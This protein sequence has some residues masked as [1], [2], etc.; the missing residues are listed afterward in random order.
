VTNAV[1]NPYGGCGVLFR[2]TPAG[3]Y[4]VLYNF[5][6]Q[7]NCTDGGMA[8]G[9]MQATNGTFYGGT[10]IGGT[11]GKCYLKKGCGVLFSLSIGLEPFVKANP[12]FGAAGHGVGIL[13]NNL[14]G[15]TSVTFNG[16]HCGVPGGLRYI[17]QGESPIGSDEWHH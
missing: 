6:S 12:N 9:L 2:I 3:E 5:C 4:T 16:T 14:K 11:A 7:A 1:C 8:A 17:H 13:G 15:A 10:S